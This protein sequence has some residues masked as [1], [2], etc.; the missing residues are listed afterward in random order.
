M[1]RLYSQTYSVTD[2]DCTDYTVYTLKFKT[3]STASVI[4][5]TIINIVLV[6]YITIEASK[7]NHQRYFTRHSRFE[8]TYETTILNGHQYFI[9]TDGA[10]AI[11]CNNNSLHSYKPGLF[12]L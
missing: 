10:K 8:P 5:L 6:S 4:A 9:T 7:P 1:Y 2:S 3:I 11:S 12:K